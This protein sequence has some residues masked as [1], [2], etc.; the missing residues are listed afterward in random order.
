MAISFRCDGI[1]ISVATASGFGE[2]IDEGAQPNECVDLDSR[3]IEPHDARASRLIEHPTGNH[4]PQFGLIV[5]SLLSFYADQH[6]GITALSRPSQDGHFAIEKR[7]KPITDPR[8]H[9]LAGSVWIR[10][11]TV[12]RRHCSTRAS[13]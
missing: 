8:R 2:C 6:A 13:T 12:S 11:A 3:L 7:M 9:E 5:L 4:D 10:C 1:R